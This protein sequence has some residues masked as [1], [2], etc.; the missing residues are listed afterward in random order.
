VKEGIVLISNKGVFS[1]SAKKEVQAIN[2]TVFVLFVLAGLGLA[3]NTFGSLRNSTSEELDRMQSRIEIQWYQE[4]WVFAVI[5]GFCTLLLVV[6]WKR[7]FPHNVPLAIIM[8]GFWFEFLFQVT[9]TGW[10]GLVGLVGLAVAIAA[11]LI[12]MFVYA[13]GERRWNLRGSR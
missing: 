12:M 7:L 8:G 13:L 10:A 2:W 1:L 4:M 11:G 5:L 6:F 3:G 9:V